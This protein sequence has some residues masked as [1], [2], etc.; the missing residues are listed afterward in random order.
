MR[1]L[2]R[3]ARRLG[4]MR[5]RC[6]RRM[7]WR[8]DRRSRLGRRGLRHWLGCGRLR[9]RRRTCRR[10][11]KRVAES[12]GHDAK[13]RRRIEAR[14]LGAGLGGKRLR[15]GWRLKCLR[16]VRVRRASGMRRVRGHG[17]NDR[18]WRNRAKRRLGAWRRCSQRWHDRRRSDRR[19]RNRR[20]SDRRRRN[21][22]CC[23]RWRDHRRSKHRGG[24]HGLW[25][26]NRRQHD[27]LGHE[28][29]VHRPFDLGGAP[30][31]RRDW[32]LQ[33]GL[34]RQPV[35][36]IG[37]REAPLQVVALSRHLLL[38][39]GEPAPLLALEELQ[40]DSF[41][42]QHFVF[43]LPGI[44]PRGDLGKDVER[45]KVGDFTHGSQRKPALPRRLRLRIARSF[46]APSRCHPRAACQ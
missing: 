44:D 9:T 22:R 24:R 28:I 37:V 17:R 4:R 27:R 10:H 33:Q 46:W 31:A 21:R 30:G 3:R 42:A 40:A 14:K 8:R 1:T 6:L 36:C 5:R 43:G 34:R 39:I 11:P 32:S 16:G 25:W 45:Q 2:E 35:A 41:F 13:G 23:A 29:R 26:R 7:R 38:D 20:R 18:R 19:R 15:S 12:T